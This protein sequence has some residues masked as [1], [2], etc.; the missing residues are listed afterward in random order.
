M[1]GI[2]LF[3][4]L[5]I[6]I[7][8]FGKFWHWVKFENY[9]DGLTSNNF[10]LYFLRKKIKHI[11]RFIGTTISFNIR[12]FKKFYF[13]YCDVTDL[14]IQTYSQI[15][16]RRF[17]E[18]QWIAK[19]KSDPEFLY[20]VQVLEAWYN[21]GFF[22]KVFFLGLLFFFI[23]FYTKLIKYLIS[24]IYIYLLLLYNDFLNI[25]IIKKIYIFF[26]FLYIILKILRKKIKNKIKNLF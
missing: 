17:T 13:N 4:V 3:I 26:I 20:M 15:N 25:Y 16:Y 1:I 12:K 7:K 10:L 9:L 14:E 21:F 18:D 2:I 5:S 22:S 24:N 19:V 6:Y 11:I 8:I 23:W